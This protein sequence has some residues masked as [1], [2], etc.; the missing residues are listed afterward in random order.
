MKKILS[1]LSFLV[2]AAGGFAQEAGVPPGLRALV[3]SERAFSKTSEAKG[4]REAF[5]TYLADDAIL[6]RPHPVPGKKWLSERPARPGLLTWQPIFADLSRAGDLGYTTGPWEFRQNGP[7]DKPAGY[8]NYVT[9]WKKQ[10]GGSWKVVIDLGTSN[11]PPTT[12]PATLQ[13]PKNNLSEKATAGVKAGLESEKSS[14]L[15]LEREFSEAS[16]EKGTV[17]A[18]LSYTADDVR[19]FRMDA[20]PIVG[21]EATRAALSGNTG[22]LTWQPAKA[23]V[24]RSEDLGYTYGAYELRANSADGQPTENGYYVRIWKKRADG[25]WKVV[26]DILN[27]IPPTPATN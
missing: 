5:L 21:K 23:D 17:N 8:G 3:E 15:K 27:P 20:F 2:L 11:P 26:L 22:V 4:T 14:L 10:P 9:V 12:A 16:K 19:L 18:F 1:L 24:A 25:D 13:Y 7:A 6:F